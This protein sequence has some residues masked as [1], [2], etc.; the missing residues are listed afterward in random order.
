MI[1]NYC[2]VTNQAF[3]LYSLYRYCVIDHG[4]INAVVFLDLRRA[5]DY[6]LPLS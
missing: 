3:V 2:Q 6:T 5:Y 1:V 4:N